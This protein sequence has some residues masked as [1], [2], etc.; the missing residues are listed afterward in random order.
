M[1][2]INRGGGRNMTR[3]KNDDGNKNPAGGHPGRA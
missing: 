2:I 3:F 1:H